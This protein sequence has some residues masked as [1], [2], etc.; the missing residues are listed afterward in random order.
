MLFR[1][2]TSPARSP[3]SVAR[4]SARCGALQG[5][6]GLTQGPVGCPDRGKDGALGAAVAQLPCERQGGWKH[7]EGSGIL[8]QPVVS[9][10]DSIEIGQ[11][12]LTVA[13]L[14]RPGQQLL[15]GSQRLRVLTQ[16]GVG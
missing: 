14:P 8:P 15:Q 1:A 4:V 12:L 9:Q 16:A 13:K 7:F 2:A 6:G 11:F 3:S 10:P 5:L